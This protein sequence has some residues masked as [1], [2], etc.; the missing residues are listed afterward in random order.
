M[1]G[2]LLNIN[3]KGTLGLFKK[4]DLFCKKSYV[5]IFLTYEGRRKG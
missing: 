5:K 2:S 4:Q 3:V 1:E